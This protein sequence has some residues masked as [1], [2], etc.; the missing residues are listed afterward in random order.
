MSK[1]FEKLILKRFMELQALSNVDFIGNQHHGFKKYKST[2][3]A[4]LLIQSIIA[5]HVDVNE[6]VGM[7]SL[8]LVQHLTWSISSS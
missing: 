4:G 5:E 6:F 2:A 7:A 1:V 3:T 8:D